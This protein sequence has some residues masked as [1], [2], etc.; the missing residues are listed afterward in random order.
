[1]KRWHMEGIV[2]VANTT[3]H[4]LAL[5]DTGRSF[6]QLTEYQKRVH[7]EPLLVKYLRY[8]IG[9]FLRVF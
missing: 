3:N 2:N 9:Q 6:M 5:P 8:V 4:K 7:R 1:M